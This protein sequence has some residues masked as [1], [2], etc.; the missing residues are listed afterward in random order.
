M[1]HLRSIGQ[2]EELAGLLALS[3]SY[4]LAALKAEQAPPQG[5]SQNG[6]DT[7]HGEATSGDVLAKYGE[8]EEWG[9]VTTQTGYFQEF[10]MYGLTFGR[11][12][13]IL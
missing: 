2:L 3:Q 13:L 11:K 4:A 5:I 10:P 8:V 7:R 9:P 1:D 6:P 12:W